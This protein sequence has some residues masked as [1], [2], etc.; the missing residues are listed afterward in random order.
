MQ[1][2]QNDSRINTWSQHIQIQTLIPIEK[3]RKNEQAGRF[4]SYNFSEKNEEDPISIFI[5]L[6]SKR[7]NYSFL[8][9]IN[10]DI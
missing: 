5:S 1:S 6:I 4:V 3:D 9:N 10:T 8:N 7:R 2:T